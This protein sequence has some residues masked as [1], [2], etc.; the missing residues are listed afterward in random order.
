MDLARRQDQP[1]SDRTTELGRRAF[2]LRVAGHTLPKIVDIL[3]AT[4]E[5]RHLGGALT[6]EAV[7]GA[8]T[9]Y[10]RGLP[11]EDPAVTRAVEAVRVE[12]LLQATIGMPPTVQTIALASRLIA[13]LRELQ[14]AE[15]RIQELQ[16]QLSERQALAAAAAAQGSAQPDWV[17]Q[18]RAA[19]EAAR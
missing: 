13:Q 19:R 17:T 2:D 3:R 1:R 12:G 14:V 16:A 7:N 4:P 5:Y 6:V 8:L 18:F 11:R 10:V 15:L 9:L